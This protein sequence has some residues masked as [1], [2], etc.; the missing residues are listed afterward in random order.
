LN[1]SQLYKQSQNVY[2]P[3]SINLTLWAVL[4]FLLTPVELKTFKSKFQFITISS[5]MF[6]D[7]LLIISFCR[8]ANDATAFPLLLNFDHFDEFL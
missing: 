1:I 8:Y 4:T 5:Y 3:P 7:Y 2:Q 6:I